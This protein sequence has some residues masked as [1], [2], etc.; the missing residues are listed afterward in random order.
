MASSERTFG[1]LSRFVLGKKGTREL[2][3]TQNNFDECLADAKKSTSPQKLREQLSDILQDVETKASQLGGD[4]EGEDEQYD[5]QQPEN[6]EAE[7]GIGAS[8]ES[9]DRSDGSDP[10][11]AE[12]RCA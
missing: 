3:D 1:F 2:E 8:S 11:D 9:A 12:E 6:R 5:G 4:D 10:G 7:S